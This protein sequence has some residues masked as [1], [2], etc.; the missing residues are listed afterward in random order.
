MSLPIDT[1]TIKDALIILATAGVVVPLMHKL[2]ISPILG[3]LGAGAVLGPKG[4]GAFSTDY[5]WLHWVSITAEDRIA[6][7]ADLGVV[8]LLFVIGLELSWPRLMTMRRKV[9]GL[10]SL[11]V[12]ASALV[13]GSIA[14]ASGQSTAASVILGT[15]LALSSTAIVV[16]LLAAQN[17]MA[18]ATG[19]VSFAVLLFQDLAVVPI[20]FLVSFLSQ[21]NSNDILQSLGLA[22]GQ[23]GLIIGIVVAF[24]RVLMRRLF[25]LVADTDSPELFI[26][27]TLFVVIG[28][29]ALTQMAGMSMSMGAFIAGLLLAETE[30]RRAIETT[31]SPFKGLLLGVFFFSV[32]MSVDMGV[33]LRSPALLFGLALALVVIK[34]LIFIVLARGFKVPWPAAVESALLLGSGGEFAFIVISLAMTAQILDAHIGALILTV[35]SISMAAIPVIGHMGYRLS[36]RIEQRFTSSGETILPPQDGTVRAIV[37][38]Y[39]R[40]GQLVSQMLTQH[41]IAFLATDRNATTV[42]RFMRQ[43]KPVYYG[44]AANPLFLRICGLHEASALIIT[45][46]I[47]SVID[48]I[49]G[50]A[51]QLRPDM[52]IIARARD[53]EH[54]KHLYRL[55]V[56]NAVPETIEASLQLSEAALLGLRIPMG[57]I[58]ASIHEKRDEFRR[59]FQEIASKMLKKHQKKTEL[60]PHENM[61]DQGER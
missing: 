10:G 21:D 25:R 29:G 20:L 13:L 31:I 55:G 56:T 39:G 4:I 22:L 12:V 33:L 46:D 11:Q 19:R 54:A 43:G 28:T 52:P 23:A 58:I 61:T 53:A 48:E 9:F 41:N 32:G 42:S 57:L 7:I 18:K 5:P 27:A 24:G 6:G 15:S 44:D 38:G 34:S 60:P 14:A 3:F 36:K 35:V 51:R 37:V 1:A 40:V 30:Y 49:V 47:P 16:E 17:R 8:F 26:A 59:D 45:I 2:K 50:V